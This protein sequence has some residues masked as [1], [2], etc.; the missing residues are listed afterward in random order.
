MLGAERTRDVQPTAFAV[1]THG[2]SGRWI[3]VVRGEIDLATVGMIED[4]L[5]SLGG[6]PVVL[7]LSGVT[8][9]DSTGVALLIRTAGR[10]SIGPISPEVASMIQT[11]RLED[12]LS[13]A[14]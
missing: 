7:D 3:V 4:E 1:E 12:E 10:L 11:C 6:R 2:R 13:F 9:L 14:V 8:F 5:A